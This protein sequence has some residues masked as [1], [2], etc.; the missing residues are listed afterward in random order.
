MK[1]LI[2]EYYRGSSLVKQQ[3]DSYNV[4]VAK[5]IQ[6]IINVVGRIKTNVKGFEIK[7]G[8]VRIEPPRY[9]EAR[10]GYKKILPAEARIRNISYSS[11]IFLEMVPIFNGVERPVY[12]DIFI[13]EMPIMIKSELCYLHGKS[14]KE[15]VEAMEDPD[16]PGG[17]FI[18]NGTERAL[19]SIEDLVPN[20][21]LVTHEKEKIVAKIF[22]TRQGFRARCV[23]NRSVDGNYTVEFPSAP[24]ALPFI[25]L[26]RVLGMDNE[27]ILEAFSDS[28]ILKNDALLN[29]ES[30][31]TGNKE[32]AIE[33]ISKRLSP[34]QP[35]E[36]RLSR[37]ESL[38]DNYL[39]PHIGSGKDYRLE[40]AQFLIYLATKATLVYNKKIPPDD[41]DHYAN[42]RVKLAGNLMHELF[43]Y[44]FQFL[45]RDI[46]YQTSRAHARGRHLNINTLI[47]QDALSDRIR[48]AM[49]TGNWIASQTGVSQLLDRTSYIATVSHL[50]RIVSPLSKR[51][52]H[53]EAR[54]LHGTHLGRLCPSETPEG[55]NCSLVKNLAIMAD[56]SIGSDEQEVI[57][58]LNRI[59]IETPGVKYE[60]E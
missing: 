44:A 32:E 4:F 35:Q 16:D 24:G 48:Y 58:T 57:E 26:L 52:P 3:L 31:A 34:G 6:E 28:R 45:V 43:R 53:F 20:K 18:I 42:K 1:G 14:K 11:P 5:E 23:V 41:K 13:G 36:F 55:P 2:T 60:E 56:I 27:Q 33:Y 49:A 12:S 8:K 21:L 15:L 22:S 9:Y 54:D 47:R 29:L 37:M 25:A 50:R 7:L 40:K 30:D 39:L 38:I 51:H 59:G 17:Y 19:I 46:I 10:G